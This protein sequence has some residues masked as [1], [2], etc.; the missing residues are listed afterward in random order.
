MT[1]VVSV[2]STLVKAVNVPESV[3]ITGASL[4]LV[5]LTVSVCV[6]SSV[7]EPL[8]VTFTVTT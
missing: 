3:V 2:F 8:S 1:T 5:T 7:G 4:T 6:S